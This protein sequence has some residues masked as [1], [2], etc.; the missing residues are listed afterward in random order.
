MQAHRKTAYRTID[1]TDFL[2][3][4]SARHKRLEPQA[5]HEQIEDAIFEVIGSKSPLRERVNDNPPRPRPTAP[6]ILPLTTRIMVGAIAVLERQLLKLS[7]P[8]FSTLLVSAFFLVFWFCGGF[9]ALNPDRMA[10]VPFSPFMVAD[11]TFA[12]QDA[13]GMKVLSVTGRLTNISD[14]SRSVPILRVTSGDG[15]T[16]FGR[17]TLRADH[18]APS[19]SIRFSGKFRLAGGKVGDIAI[20]PVT[21]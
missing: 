5:G 1:A 17:I 4:E 13:N 15:R 3:P 14:V 2:P 21:D 9:G 8:A 10:P 7:A 16:E 18:L 11:S 19:D 6:E 12:A 20:I